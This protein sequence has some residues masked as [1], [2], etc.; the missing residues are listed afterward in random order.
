MA[1]PDATTEL[2]QPHH[3]LDE[4][5]SP[6]PRLFPDRLARGFFWRCCIM[7]DKTEIAWTDSTFNPWW[8]CTKIASGCDNCYAAA[9]DKRTGGDH[10]NPHSKPRRFLSIEPLIEDL[11]DID[12]AGIHW[13][14]VGGESGHHARPMKYEWVLSIRN[15]CLQQGV[16]FFFKQW[17]GRKRDKGGC[18]FGGSEVKEWP[19]I[20]GA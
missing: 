11:G 8:G 15:Q 16:P 17:G 20:E 19:S 10:W 14:I 12:L 4:V 13:V 9:F 1:K 2:L 18:L 3:P 6:A 7:A 5:L